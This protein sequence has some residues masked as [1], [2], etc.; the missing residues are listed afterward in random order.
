MRVPERLHGS[1]TRRP[2][3]TTGARPPVE[4]L[5]SCSSYRGNLEALE[6]FRLEAARMVTFVWFRGDRR[7]RLSYCGAIRTVKRPLVVQGPS[8]PKSGEGIP[9]H[10]P[11]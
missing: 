1:A 4:G 9:L 3:P 5:I 8:E 10:A 6:A 2:L 11:P 7:P